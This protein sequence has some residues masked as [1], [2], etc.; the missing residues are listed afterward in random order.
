M[1]KHSKKHLFQRFDVKNAAR[2]RFLRKKIA[3]Q[4]RQKPGPATDGSLQTVLA[5][6]VGPFG[7]PP[8]PSLA[9][10]ACKLEVKDEPQDNFSCMSPSIPL[11]VLR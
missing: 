11:H 10:P 7:D 2:R 1:A 5:K 8:L 4:T 6:L 3:A 9:L